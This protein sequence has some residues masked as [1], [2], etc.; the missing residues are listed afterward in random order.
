MLCFH[1]Y[2]ITKIFK[3]FLT[4]VLTPISL[5]SE[6]LSF[7]EFAAVCCSAVV[8]HSINP[9]CFFEYHGSW[10]EQARTKRDKKMSQEGGG[11]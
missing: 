11:E 9:L 2:S 3:A 6:L 10:Q 4:S 5:I 8:V 1:F 7:H